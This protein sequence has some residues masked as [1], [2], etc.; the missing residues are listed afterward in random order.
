MANITLL[1]QRKIEAG[2][3]VPLIK[4]FQQE[5][6]VERATAVA[7]EVIIGLARQ[8]GRQFGQS[9][10]GSP[11]DKIESTL[12]RFASGGALEIEL[13][14]RTDDRLGFNVT[15]CRYAEAYHEMGIPPE[16]G[17]LLSCNRD[18]AMTEGLSPDL[19]LTRTQ[20]IMQG[21]SFCDFRFRRRD[22]APAE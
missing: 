20:T 1:E 12:P 3:L 10:A 11:I 16:L 5:F 18:Y 15:R 8:S 17:A 13:V 19:E 4:A 9:I 14:E 6:G 2:V 7:R 22:A 21:A